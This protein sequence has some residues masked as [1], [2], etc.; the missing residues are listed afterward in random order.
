MAPSPCLQP[1][2]RSREDDIPILQKAKLDG[3]EPP[4]CSLA[5]WPRLYQPATAT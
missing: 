5:E 2:F 1:T 4:L 3:R